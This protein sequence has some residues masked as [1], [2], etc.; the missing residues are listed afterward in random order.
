[1]V[2]RVITLLLL[3]ELLSVPCAA[4]DRVEAYIA[5]LDS[6]VTELLVRYGVPSAA[7]AVIHGGE[8]YTRTWGSANL[9]T[10]RAPSDDTLYNV[11]SISKL[12]TAWAVMR[13]VEENRVSLD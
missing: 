11:A 5:R 7:V 4:L 8:T 6:G 12:V 1:M 3:L 13:L 9:Q 2:R 10:G